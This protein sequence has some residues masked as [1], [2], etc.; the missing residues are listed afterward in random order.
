[1]TTQNKP[2]R[3]NYNVPQALVPEVINLCDQQGIEPS[4]WLRKIIEKALQESR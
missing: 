3:L 1:M 4:Y 2:P